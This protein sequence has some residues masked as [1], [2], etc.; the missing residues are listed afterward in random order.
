MAE[1]FTILIRI[2]DGQREGHF[3]K[4]VDLERMNYEY[5]PETWPATHR[6]TTETIMGF[7]DMPKMQS[8]VP[9][10]HDQVAF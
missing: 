8:M 6:I 3:N 4:P 5:I 9:P 7:K 2:L 1:P 10:T